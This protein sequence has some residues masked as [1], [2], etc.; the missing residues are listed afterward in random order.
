MSVAEVTTSKDDE[1]IA[2]LHAKAVSRSAIG[3]YV[4]TSLVWDYGQDALTLCVEVTG[5][6]SYGYMFLYTRHEMQSGV[7]RKHGEFE[8]RVLF[9]LEEFKNL[10]PDEFAPIKMASSVDYSLNALEEADKFIEGHK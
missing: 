8:R 2:Y 4:D 6:N 1:Y 7:W 3:L 9:A 5:R 10:H